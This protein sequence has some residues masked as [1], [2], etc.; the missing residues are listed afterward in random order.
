[1]N[2]FQNSLLPLWPPC[3]PGDHEAAIRE[4]QQELL[5]CEV[6][7]DVIG[8]AVANRRIGECYA[9]MGNIEAALKVCCFDACNFFFLTCFYTEVLKRLLALVFFST[10]SATWIWLV[11]FGIIQRNKEPWLL[12][13]VPTCSVMSR[14]SRGAAWRKRRMPSEKAC[15]LWMI[16]STVCVP[17]GGPRILFGPSLSQTFKI[18]LTCRVGACTRAQWDESSPV[19]QPGSGPWSPGGLQTLQRVHTPQ[20]LHCWVHTS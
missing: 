16:V 18:Y 13:V 14:T 9:E 17:K 2:W 11:L 5:L 1:M 12:L 3:V 10:R 19:P 6:L 8:R 7:K 15:L 20:C 4:H